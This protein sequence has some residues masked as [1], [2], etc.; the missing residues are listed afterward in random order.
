[1]KASR[2]AITTMP[3]RLAA[4]LALLGFIF[5]AS[6]SPPIAG[7]DP[8]GGSR[9]CHASVG[10]QNAPAGESAER[11]ECCLLCQAAQLAKGA[12]PAAEIIL[13]E[14]D[15]RHVRP[16]LHSRETALGNAARH[17]QARAPP[18]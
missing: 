15:A 13:A 17:A 7:F 6:A 11:E 10:E 12:A 16:A 3:G 5:A 8:V 14:P 9:L 1:M 4:L 18:A 2:T